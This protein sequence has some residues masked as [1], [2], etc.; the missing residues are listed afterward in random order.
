M[1]VARYGVNVG[2]PPFLPGGGINAT[3]PDLPLAYVFVAAS[4][5][6]QTGR[7][8]IAQNFRGSCS[9]TADEVGT[10]CLFSSLHQVKTA[11]QPA[12]SASAASAASG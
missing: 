11:N 5:L 2:S 7:P 10:H 3:G 8:C 12:I 9:D 6:H 4:Q 1:T